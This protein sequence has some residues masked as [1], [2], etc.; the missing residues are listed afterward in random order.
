MPPADY[1]ESLGRL[2]AWA[3]LASAFFSNCESTC[4][5]PCSIAEYECLVLK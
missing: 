5:M 4:P 2:S 3:T 1:P